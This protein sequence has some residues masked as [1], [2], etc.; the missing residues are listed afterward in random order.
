MIRGSWFGHHF[1]M[2]IL[3]LNKGVLLGHTTR[4]DVKDVELIWRNSHCPGSG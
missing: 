4:C 1:V 2:Q 3:P